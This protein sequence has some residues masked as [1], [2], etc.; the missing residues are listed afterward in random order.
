[1]TALHWQKSSY[2]EAGSTCVHLAAAPGVV[3]LRESDAPGVILAT[4]P[5]SLRPLLARVKTGTLSA[6]DP[7]GRRYPRVRRPAS[8]VPGS[9]VAHGRRPSP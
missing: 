4:T 3:L 9:S 6:S 8:V 7:G 1:M 5:A 2:C